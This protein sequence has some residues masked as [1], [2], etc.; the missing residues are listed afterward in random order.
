ME[1]SLRSRLGGRRAISWQAV[2]I[3]DLLIVTLAT[4]L[5]A[6][7]AA[8]RTPL[9][10]ATS[11]FAITMATAVLAA[12]YTGL[13]H[14]TVFRK[15]AYKPV[16]ISAA[17][18][19][20][21]SIGVI[22]LVGF[23]VGAAILSVP[24][25]GGSPSFSI[26]V[27]LGGLLVCLPT[28][29]LLDHSDRYRAAHQQLT[30]QLTEYERL[31]VSEWSMRQALRSL[32]DKITD[33]MTRDD[34]VEH[35]DVLDLSEDTRLSTS[36]W[37][38]A[39][40]A[41]HQGGSATG[42]GKLT[43]Q[44][45]DGSR[46]LDFSAVISDLMHRDFPTIRWTREF[47]TWRRSVAPAPGFA[48]ALVLFMT[49]LFLTP[50]LPSASALPISLTSAGGAYAIYALNRGG[51]LKV[52]PRVALFI[53]SSWGVVSAVGWAVALPTITGASTTS[54]PGIAVL[55]GL[56]AAFALVIAMW[57]SGVVAARNEQLSMLQ[58]VIERRK[59]ESTAVFASLTSVVARMADAPP[60]SESTALAACATGLQRVQ[61]ARDPVRARRIIEWTHSVLTAPGVWSTAS[62]AG[63][64]DEVVHPW[65]ALADISI[66]CPDDFNEPMLMDDVVAVVD[67]AVR[68][69]CRHGGAG[70]ISV[71][72]T[73]ESV[74]LVQIEVLDDGSG[75]GDGVAGVGLERFASWGS[76]NFEVAAR[77]PGPGTRVLV[78][79]D[80]S[81]QRHAV[82]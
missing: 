44:F 51:M 2:V 15:R 16:P 72:V 48:S 11:V 81:Q 55:A 45:G 36:M 58:S 82:R 75:L 37:W 66:D 31:R 12:A 59:T 18:G 7:S 57:V 29:F 47:P 74:T 76:G 13:M 21:L 80:A 67:E 64:I 4:G 60:L 9:E 23:A 10:A 46:Q 43:D 20:H 62:L 33:Q 1:V 65:R 38:Q 53:A 32:A 79:L 70:T 56:G 39:S 3:G 28:S 49:W 17:V 26:A 35:L 40:Q 73:V 77:V 19:F 34:V 5:A 50:S 8:G 14:L 71:N 30:Q 63:R 68:N 24:Q 54:A 52:A 69:A 25:L 61:T 6:A 78:R 27:L 22:F 42:P 41:H